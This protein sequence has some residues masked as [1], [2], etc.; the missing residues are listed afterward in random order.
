LSSTGQGGLGEIDVSKE[1]LQDFVDDNP[2]SPL[3]NDA[4]QVSTEL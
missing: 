3:A 2:K 4:K 1:A